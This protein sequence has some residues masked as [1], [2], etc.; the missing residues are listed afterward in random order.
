LGEAGIAAFYTS[1]PVDIH[2][3]FHSRALDIA[4]RSSLAGDLQAS[5][6]AGPILADGVGQLLANRAG[7]RQVSRLGAVAA[8]F[9]LL[10]LLL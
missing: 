5:G 2:R 4:S 8:G 9:A 7:G 1:D 6:G 3:L 10:V